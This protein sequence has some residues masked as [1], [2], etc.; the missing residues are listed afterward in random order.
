MNN[1]EFWFDTAGKPINAHGGGMLEYGGRFYWYGE[2]KTEGWAGRLAFHGVH[3]YESANLMDWR[4][5]G[6]VLPVSDDP[7]SPIVRGCRIERPK[8]IYCRTT[9]KFVMYFHST[10][11]NHTIAKRGLAAADSPEGPFVFLG[12]ARVNAGFAPLNM[13]AEE[14][15]FPAGTIPPEPQLPN[16]EN[17]EVKRYPIFRRDLAAGQMARDMNLFV[18]EDGTAY[19]IYSSEHNSTIHIAELTPDCLGW[20]GRYVRVLPCGW[21]EGMALFRRGDACHLLMSGCTS[22][23]PNAARSAS[24]P[25]VFG[26]WTP[27]GNPCRGPGA[28]T[29]FGCQSSAVFR[30]G[31][32]WIAMFDRWNPA[33]FDRSTY[34]WL[35][36][37]FLSDDGYRIDWTDEIQFG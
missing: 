3:C 14:A 34:V 11:E 24:A 27:G 31:E 1:R 8:V 17:D 30:A 21:N 28:E 33:S 19:H 5:C 15:A 32:R 18:D 4:D 10:D 37:R 6:I 22:W 13:S 25:G 26:P 9:G 35:E 2:H 36:I 23:E 16:G 12:A 20:S 29:T 7:A